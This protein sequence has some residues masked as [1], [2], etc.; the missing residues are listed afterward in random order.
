MDGGRRGEVVEPH[1]QGPTVRAPELQHAHAALVPHRVQPPLVVSVVRVRVDLVRPRHEHQLPQT[2]L[3]FASGAAPLR[4]PSQSSPHFW[5]RVA[6]PPSLGWVLLH[7]LSHLY[8]QPRLPRYPHARA[9]R[10]PFQRAGDRPLSSVQRYFPLLVGLSVPRCPI[11]QHR[12]RIQL[13]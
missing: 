9:Q 11:P 12:V 2:R 10:P 4:A 6:A 5:L 7:A 13:R 3:L 1:V 8:S